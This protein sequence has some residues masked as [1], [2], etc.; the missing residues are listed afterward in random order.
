MP[1]I[2]RTSPLE[3][4]MRAQT[5]NTPE[6]IERAKRTVAHHATDADDARRILGQLGLIDAPRKPWR[7]A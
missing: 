6:Q 5:R 3:E 2:I 7:R 1:T 4:D